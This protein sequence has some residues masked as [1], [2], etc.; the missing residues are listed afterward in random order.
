MFTEREVRSAS[1][2]AVIGSKASHELFGPVNPVGQTVR[3][4]NIPFSVIGLLESKGAGIGG[5]NQDDRIIVPYT[6]G[7]GTDAVARGLA[8]QLSEAWGQP[9]VVE[10]RPG[11]STMIG[12]DHVA[13][14]VT[15]RLRFGHCTAEDRLIT[16]L[17]HQSV[18]QATERLVG[19][20]S[21]LGSI[22]IWGRCGIHGGD[23]RSKLGCGTS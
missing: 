3:I 15:L 19:R 22:N 17:R 21:E 12:A 23:H 11:G 20:A 14:L 4:R 7:G 6:A 1:R 16:H 8:N 10:N 9:V 5:Q 2:V 18:I 13:K